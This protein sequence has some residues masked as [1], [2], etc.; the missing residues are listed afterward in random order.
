MLKHDSEKDTHF[1]AI[2]FPELGIFT[3]FIWGNIR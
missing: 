1:P 2:D 3:H